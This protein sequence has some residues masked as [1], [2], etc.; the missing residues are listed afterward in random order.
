MKNYTEFID[1]MVE[2]GKLSS[3]GCLEIFSDKSLIETVQYYNENS[4]EF[5]SRFFAENGQN[6]D[7]I[8]FTLMFFIKLSFLSDNI[9]E[10]FLSKLKT[11]NKSLFVSLK[12]DANIP[13]FLADENYKHIEKNIRISSKEIDELK[14]NRDELN[15]ELLGFESE[16]EK[17]L[18]KQKDLT[19]SMR[20]RINEKERLELTKKDLEQKYSENKKRE[21]ESNFG[22][23]N[24]L[25]EKFVKTN[26]DGLKNMLLN[27][28]D[29]NWHNRIT[30]VIDRNKG[31]HND[32]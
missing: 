10:D 12:I 17:L 16:K 14:Q 9:I 4:S 2:L 5:V 7:V 32:K 8:K 27:R 13:H 20:D 11:L 25:K 23:K 6:E 30:D 1:R 19:E 29:S 28:T 18:K 15:K 26:I 3:D 21:M 22:K 31:C 24:S